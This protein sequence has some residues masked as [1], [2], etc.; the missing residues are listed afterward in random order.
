MEYLFERLGSQFRGASQTMGEEDNM[1]NDVRTN[2]WI[3]VQTPREYFS[4]KLTK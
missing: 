4:S 1:E 3:L 2:K